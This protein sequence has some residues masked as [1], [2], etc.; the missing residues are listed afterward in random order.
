M[1]HD[2][3]MNISEVEQLG[4]LLKRS[5][6]D[7]KN[8]IAQ[9]EKIVG[10][11]G[12]V[13]PVSG[14]FKQQ[15]W[16]NHRG[17][18]ASASSMLAEFGELARSNAREQA[19][20]SAANAALAGGAV[21]GLTIPDMKPQSP[22][23]GRLDTEAE[24]LK[25]MSKAD[26]YLNNP[27]MSRQFPLAMDQLREWRT[28]IGDDVPSEVEAAQLERYLAAIQLANYQVGIVRDAARLGFAEF[29]EMAKAAGSAATGSVGGDVTLIKGLTELVSERVDGFVESTVIDPAVDV[30]MDNMADYLAGSAARSF[31]EKLAGM[32]ATAQ[33]TDVVC[34]S[35][36]SK[37]ALGN[38]QTAS[39][40]IEQARITGDTADAFNPLT[41]DGSLIDS[42][43][44]TGLKVLPGVGGA[45]GTALDLAGMAGSSAQAS[46]RYEAGV[47]AFEVVAQQFTEF[48]RM[49]RDVFKL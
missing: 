34:F 25:L 19:Q 47:M 20:A 5:S 36:P 49:T 22:S 40:S 7:L 23:A 45:A 6:H 27:R 30:T 35:D 2:A 46:W 15:W 42:A 9:L 21:A 10:A 12:W 16:P 41:G 24:R 26:A 44:R 29:V 3:G 48:D 39:L 14:R 28:R 33:S 8:V 31:D 43:L 11:A 18:L 17:A 32:A 37:L 1:S 13:G 4:A 38:Y